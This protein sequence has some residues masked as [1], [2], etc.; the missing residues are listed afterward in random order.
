M[1]RAHRRVSSDAVR[2]NSRTGSHGEF[3]IY[4]PRIEGGKRT[5]RVRPLVQPTAVGAEPAVGFRRGVACSS[6][7]GICLSTGTT[8]FVNGSC[9]GSRMYP[10][11]S[12]APVKFLPWRAC[13]K[14]PRVCCA[15]EVD[16]MDYT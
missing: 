8:R 15:M 5:C 16:G 11:A 2:W 6:S 1:L 4:A 7:S 3:E 14:S 10:I 9:S 12:S 13:Q